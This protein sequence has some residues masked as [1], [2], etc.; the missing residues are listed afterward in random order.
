MNSKLNL[1]S[2]AS[3]S[4]INLVQIIVT[5]LLGFGI[6]SIVGRTLGTEGKGIYEVA[7][8]L[9]IMLQWLFNLGITTA[10]TYYVAHGDHD[11]TGATRG[12][13]SLSFWIS[14]FGSVVGLL[15]AYFAGFAVFP[16]IPRAVLL[17]SLAALPFL[18]FRM[19]LNAILQGL[20]DFRAYSLVEI[21]P[22]IVTFTL[23][24]ILMLASSVQVADVVVFYLLG[25]VVAAIAVIVILKRRS[26]SSQPL[27]SL[28]IDRTYLKQMLNYGL[29]S[30]LNIISIYL[31]LRV[32]VLLINL[33][34]N[35]AASVGIYSIAVL[36]ADRVWLVSG[37]ASRIILPRIAASESAESNRTEL[38]ITITRYTFWFSVMI[39][40]GLAV[41]GEWVIVLIY[42]EA[43]GPAIH[44][45]LAILPGVILFNFGVMLS[46]D[47]AG[48]GRP[49][50]TA[51]QAAIAFIINLVANLI[52]IPRYDYVGA[53]LASSLAYAYYGIAHI[54]IFNR[55][56][57][58]RW[59]QLLLPTQKD[60]TYAKKLT[61]ILRNR[62]KV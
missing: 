48:R 26:L 56:T 40:G 22:S 37:F 31:L 27:F 54:Y 55:M 46:S 23:L 14:L 25:N 4:L 2:F 1:R 47:I 52:L 3:D 6:T 58:T 17:L 13:I 21:I 62:L 9:P 36:F 33:V 5:V 12:N 28:R 19:N 41:L 50:I 42:G 8:L 7:I 49:D 29:K 30:Q 59:W 43:F 34:G 38:S 44:A 18:Y 60:I 45:L 51:R 20:Q 16:G 24:V 11:V 10:S 15:I 57:N 53:A 39:A 32:D 61:T 35:G